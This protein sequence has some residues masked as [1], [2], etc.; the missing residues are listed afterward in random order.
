MHNIKLTDAM[1]SQTN[2]IRNLIMSNYYNQHIP[3]PPLEKQNE[4]A[5]HIQSIRNQAR[6]LQKEAQEI[7]E[8]A[9]KEVEQII[10]GE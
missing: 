7:L 6:N 3:L 1:Q 5:Q 2:G 8:K 4:I 10:L 9:K